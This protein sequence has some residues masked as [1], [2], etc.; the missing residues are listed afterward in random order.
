[1]RWTSSFFFFI[2]TFFFDIKHSR[3]DVG[4]E[5][6]VGEVREIARKGGRE[7]EK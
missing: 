6:V 4:E 7:G 3:E 2:C 5:D 1:M